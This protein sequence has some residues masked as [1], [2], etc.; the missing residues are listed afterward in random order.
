MTAGPESAKPMPLKEKGSFSANLTKPPRASGQQFYKGGWVSV[1][2]LGRHPIQAR[3]TLA[4]CSPNQS[5]CQS[6]G[7]FAFPPHVFILAQEPCWQILSAGTN[8]LDISGRIAH[9]S[10]TAVNNSCGG[11]RS[12][13]RPRQRLVMIKKGE[14]QMSS[15]RS[16]MHQ[17]DLVI[18]PLDL[19]ATLTLPERP[20]GLVIFAHGSGSS[21][22][23]P[24]NR[25]VAAGLLACG[26]ATLLFD[27][28]TE[29]EAGDR[30][31]VFDIPLLADRLVLATR[32]LS[33]LSVVERL[34]IGYFG[35][36]TGAAAALQA[37]SYLGADIAAV[38]SRGGR[39]DLAADLSKVM[40]PTLLIVGGDDTEVLA[41]NRQALA[42]LRCDKRLS[43]VPEA[44]HLF[45]EPGT[46]E[47]V[48]KLS[49][50]WFLDYLC[51][52]P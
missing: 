23:S 12:P 4:A 13:G 40:A 29:P 42:E 6:A 47:Q 5:K 46:L 49:A 24:R 18:P 26:L 21:R 32:Y 51:P 19:P 16:A 44:T 7:A 36:S 1:M 9:H 25:Q 31:N 22:F 8:S 37:A 30:A 2:P 35:A 38:V 17:S 15:A 48:I 34:P 28:L 20:T 11:K 52:N 33:G 10:K 39:P 43:I 14:R 3:I 27:L 50:D 41:L 45:E